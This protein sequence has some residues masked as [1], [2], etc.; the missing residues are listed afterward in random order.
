M[1]QLFA[2][3]EN[4]IAEITYLYIMQGVMIAYLFI[5]STVSTMAVD[6]RFLETC[7]NL[8]VII[9]P[10]SIYIVCRCPP[11]IA[12]FNW[13]SRSI[14]D[15]HYDEVLREIWLVSDESLRYISLLS[16]LQ[17]LQFSR[18]TNVFLVRM[19]L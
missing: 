6:E 5:F 14:F 3:F 13:N 2:A 18:K 8:A 1:I 9:F 7:L 15:D 11:L 17:C 4:R 10:H 12:L 19:K 16:I